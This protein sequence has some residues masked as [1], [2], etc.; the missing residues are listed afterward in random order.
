MLFKRLNGTV[1]NYSEDTVRV[2]S[3]VDNV[4]AGANRQALDEMGSFD[5]HSTEDWQKLVELKYKTLAGQ[6]RLCSN[7]R[8]SNQ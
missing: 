5:L 4:E 2:E 8:G 7:S 1:S 6:N 3:Q